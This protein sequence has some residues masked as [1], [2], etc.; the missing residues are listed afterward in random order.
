MVNVLE[1]LHRE[2]RLKLG[3]GYDHLPV[4]RE[5]QTRCRHHALDYNVVVGR[6]ATRLINQYLSTLSEAA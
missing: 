6:Y 1:Y 2:A 5:I 3:P 4:N